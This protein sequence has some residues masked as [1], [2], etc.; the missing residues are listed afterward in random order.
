[1]SHPNAVLTPRARR[2]LVGLV[3]EQGLTLR[4]AAAAMGVSV[5]T[6]WEWL[7]APASPAATAGCADPSAHRVGAPAYRLGPAADRG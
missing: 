6:A 2:R 1:M 4:A 5:A 7:L 3:E